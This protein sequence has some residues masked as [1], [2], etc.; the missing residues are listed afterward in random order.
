MKATEHHMSEFVKLLYIGDS[1]TGKTGSLI[2]LLEAGYD[3][4]VVD[5]DNGLDSLVALCRQHNP[6]LLSHLDYQ[7]FR[8]K[9]KPD[10]TKGAKVAGTPTAYTSAIE[11]LN[12]WDDGT[13]P[14]EWGDKTVL[15]LDSLSSFGRSAFLWAQGMQPS[16]KDG[17]QWYGTAQESVKVVLELLSSADFRCNVIVISHVQITEMNDGTTKG[18][19]SSIGK[20]LG[21]EIPKIFNTMI[22]AESKGSGDRVKRTIQTMP[23]TLVDAK[24]PMPFA[25]ERSLPL[26]TGLATVFKTLKGKKLETIKEK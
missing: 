24:T 14:A 16:A 5:M 1:G 8:D 20:A 3:L 9:F 10:R 17:R 13:T 22:L 7:T 19:V 21:P 23:T 4:R 18:H 12:K 11:A 15:V 6:E 2:S 26:E 25:L